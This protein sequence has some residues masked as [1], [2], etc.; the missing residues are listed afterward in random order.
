MAI[1]FEVVISKVSSAHYFYSKTRPLVLG[2]RGSPGIFPEHSEGSYS[3]AY[4]ENGD[5]IELDLQVTKDGHFVTNHNPT[6]KHETNIEDFA[7]EYESRRK[8]DIYMPHP[9][10]VHLKDDFLIHDFT[11]AEIKTLKRKQV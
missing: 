5:F 6:L 3:S 1:L 11:L 10:D 4:A 8:K 7:K 9:Y 2:H